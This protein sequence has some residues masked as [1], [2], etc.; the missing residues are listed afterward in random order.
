MDPNG[1]ASG[2]GILTGMIL[3]S[4]AGTAVEG[5]AFDAVMALRK[6]QSGN[7]TTGMYDM[8]FIHPKDLDKAQRKHWSAVLKKQGVDPGD[9]LKPKLPKYTARASAGTSL[10]DQM[11]SHDEAQSEDQPTRSDE[12]EP[13]PEPELTHVDV[14][15]DGAAA[16]L[17]PADESLDLDALSAELGT[18]RSRDE[19]VSPDLDA[20]AA[21]LGRTSPALAEHAD[22]TADEEDEEELGFDSV[23]DDVEDGLGFS[24]VMHEEVVKRGGGADEDEEGKSP[25]RRPSMLGSLL[26]EP[27]AAKSVEPSLEALVDEFDEEEEEEDDNE[28]EH[29]DGEDDS[30]KRKPKFVSIYNQDTKQEDLVEQ[31]K[32]DGDDDD[33]EDDKELPMAVEAELLAVL[34][35]A[36]EDAMNDAFEAIEAVSLVVPDVPPQMDTDDWVDVQA[37]L[38]PE[39]Q[40]AC[41][42][43]TMF[44][45]PAPAAV[46]PPAADLLEVSVF[47]SAISG[48]TDEP[49][50]LDEGAAEIPERSEEAAATIDTLYQMIAELENEKAR[51]QGAL[52]DA[53]GQLKGTAEAVQQLLGVE[54]QMSEL[55]AALRASNAEA[56]VDLSETKES[57]A[58]E[59]AEL[60]E[61]KTEMGEMKAE[62]AE[63]KQALAVV[64]REMF[65]IEADT[66]A[67]VVAAAAA[68]AALES[69]SA[70][71]AAVANAAEGSVVE[72]V[73]KPSAADAKQI[74]EQAAEIESLQAELAE[75]A[76]TSADELDERDAQIAELL[77]QL[78]Q[79]TQQNTEMTAVKAEEADL[80][81]ATRSRGTISI[82]KHEEAMR[83]YTSN[84][85]LPVLSRS[86]SDILHAITGGK[87]RAWMVRL[88]RLQ[89]EHHAEQL[90]SYK[91][92]LGIATAAHES[93]R[94]QLQGSGSTAN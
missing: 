55:R 41:D 25:T 38:E 2:R 30:T 9:W 8:S 56:E 53:N 75:A 85:P 74:S 60:G 89:E 47:R 22:P 31:T 15:D 90:A 76:V 6:K 1:D 80:S 66:A 94:A 83:K 86:F 88:L 19:S 34:E 81:P 33:D 28:G 64:Q 36:I 5:M 93:Q 67:E 77:S 52:D 46:E 21:E 82:K 70:A 42:L 61:M 49:E 43:L 91:R 39:P 26:S 51:L 14:E 79:A 11:A 27:G 35:S 54:S 23:M 32:A 84:L 50:L 72:V 40:P 48:D 58:K 4:I 87:D 45:Q 13:D 17:A 12:Q 59:Q 29:V 65:H 69:A 20:M 7:A 57:L 10:E 73:A 37:E 63:L 68:A 62:N 16:E 18:S 44:H 78:E 71:V 92:Q 24:S 3:H